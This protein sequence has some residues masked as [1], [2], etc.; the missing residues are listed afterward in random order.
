MTKASKAKIAITI[1]R[2][3]LRDIRRAVKEGSAESVSAYITESL[4]QR[5]SRE[6]VIAMFDAILAETGGPPTRQEEAEAR[7]RLGLSP[8]R[9]RRSSAA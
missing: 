1:P 7:T 3:L 2:D 4:V 8:K 9:R 5:A 6:A